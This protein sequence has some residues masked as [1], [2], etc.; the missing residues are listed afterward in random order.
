VA[1]T[2]LIVYLVII[3]HCLN[4]IESNSTY[5]FTGWEKEYYGDRV[6]HESDKKR[7]MIKYTGDN[8]SEIK[9]NNICN[10]VGAERIR[11]IDNCV[12]I[13]CDYFQ[14]NILLSKL[15]TLIKIEAINAK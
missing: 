12:I 14:L 13:T 2:I 11:F 15:K 9:I 7:V 5:L 10:L 1:S 3:F 4:K 6:W 8:I